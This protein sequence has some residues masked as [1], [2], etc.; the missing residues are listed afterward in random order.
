MNTLMARIVL[1]LFLIVWHFGRNKDRLDADIRNWCEWKG[2]K[3]TSL[4]AC[5][6]FVSDKAFRNL[7]YYRSGPIRILLSWLFPGYDHLQITTPCKDFGGGCILQH[8]FA[9]II[10]AKSIGKNCKIYQQVTIGYNHNLDAPVIGDNVEICC[11]AKIIGGVTIGNNV[12]IGAN[13]VVINDIPDNC[14]VAGVPAKIVGNLP[15]NGD[16]F[17]RVHSIN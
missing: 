3:L 1:P 15:E 13:T 11:G 10:S 16:I 8:G 2:E 12:L 5:K 4:A 7:V 14:I 9:T 6:F 17:S